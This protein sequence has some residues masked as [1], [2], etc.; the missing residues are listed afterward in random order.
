MLSLPTRLRWI[1]WISIAWTAVEFAAGL[2]LGI[3]AR[4]V[5]LT[6][7]SADSAIELLS[8]V[9]VLER[10]RRGAHTEQQFARLAAALLYALAAYVVASS[11]ISLLAPRWRPEP[12]AGG[13]AVLAVS[14][15]LMQGLGFA[16]RRLAGT[17]G[18]AT[19]RAD[20]AQSQLCALLS[21]IGLAGVALNMHFGWAW[22]DP[23]AAL[24]L[25]PLILREARQAQRGELCCC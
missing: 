7:F 11:A 5:V 20:A 16:K 13:I 1:Q 12:S 18:S 9:L 8:A 14:A 2:W 22:A 19:L 15:V 3:R 4:S 24:L 10:F 6:A 17:T 23:A 21:W 25:L